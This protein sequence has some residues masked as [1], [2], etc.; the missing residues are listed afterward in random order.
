MLNT[1]VKPIINDII[2]ADAMEL[3]KSIPDGAV[4]FVFTDPP[5][6]QEAHCRG[7]D[8]NKKRALFKDMADWTNLNNSF[9]SSDWLDEYVRV[10]KIPNIALFCNESELL[11][12]LTYAKNHGLKSTRVIPILKETPIPFTNQNWLHNEFLV[13]LCDRRLGFCGDY[14]HKIPY[15]IF[16]GGVSGETSHPNEKPVIV[17]R[18]VIINCSQYNDIVLDPFAGSGSICCAS[19]MEKRRFIGGEINRKFVDAATNRLEHYKR[20]LTLF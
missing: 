18:S 17:C 1:M 15:F 19:I 2:C 13:H 14:H 11:G 20:V 7:R 4:D 16:S 8:I 12:L 10:C 5:Y 9:Y 6:S 3:L